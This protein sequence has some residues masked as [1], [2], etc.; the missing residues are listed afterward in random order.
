[1]IIALPIEIKLYI[2]KHSRGVNNQVSK[3][4]FMKSQTVFYSEIARMITWKGIL[5]TQT[6]YKC[7]QSLHGNGINQKVIILFVAKKIFFLILEAHIGAVFSS[8][9]TTTSNIT[10]WWN[11]PYQNADLVQSYNVS[12]RI[13]D[14]SYIF[15]TS[16]ELQTNYTFE[17]SFLPGHLYYFEITSVVY[18]SE[19]AETIFV[20]T[21][22]IN[23][24][25]GKN[26]SYVL[27]YAKLISYVCFNPQRIHSIVQSYVS[28]LLFK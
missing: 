18:L 26:Y 14:S 15:Q 1:M 4:S 24:V 27:V 10:V 12:L 16:V 9:K 3:K 5:I 23:L 22:V 7:C 6:H 28:R 2:H 17:S 11:P 21:D 25:V 13:F 19:S 20:K 8:S